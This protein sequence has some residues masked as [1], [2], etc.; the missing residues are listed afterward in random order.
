MKLKKIASLALAG[1]MAVSMLAG[2][3]DGGNSN[4][5]SSSENTNTASGYSAMLGQKAA[6]TLS[7][8]DR[9][10]IFTFADNDKDQKA[11]SDAILEIGDSKLESWVKKG[12]VVELTK[13]HYTDA[14]NSFKAD[15]DLDRDTL[16]D[17]TTKMFFD[18]SNAANTKKVGTIW[19][20][21][22]TV[23]MD[24]VLDKIFNA[25]EEAFKDA[26]K[27]GIIGTASTS[28]AVT[29]D[30]KYTVSVSV[31]NKPV[32]SNTQFNGSINFI[33]VTVTRNSTVA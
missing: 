21:N 6:E 13:N 16:M 30:F 4:S 15:A 33:A 25:Y 10:K 3:K 12:Y 20:A 7:D 24:K 27:T 17:N 29:Y 18:G 31:V 26:Q 5:G 22:G 19:V 8:N 23:S 32:T 9:D 14:Y 1:I 28:S 11:L 2:C